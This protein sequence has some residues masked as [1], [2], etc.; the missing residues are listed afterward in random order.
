MNEKKK[1]QETHSTAEVF[2]FF[3]GL[4]PQYTPGAFSRPKCSTTRRA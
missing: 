2:W 1:K 3:F 4:D